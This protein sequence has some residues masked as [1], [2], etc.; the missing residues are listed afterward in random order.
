MRALARF[1]RL[2][3]V[4]AFTNWEDMGD[5]GSDYWHDTVLVLRKPRR[6]P[7]KAAAVRVMQSLQR[8]ALTWRLE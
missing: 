6:T 1:A 7:A 3:C 5:P 4:E 8:R 2:E